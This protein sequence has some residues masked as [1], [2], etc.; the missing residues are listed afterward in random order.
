M[1]FAC[2]GEATHTANLIIYCAFKEE[3]PTYQTS[4]FKTAAFC[5]FF[6]VYNTKKEEKKYRVGTVLLLKP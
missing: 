2:W 1:C 5:P 4:E 3:V 6:T